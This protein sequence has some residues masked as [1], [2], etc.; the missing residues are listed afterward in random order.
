[1]N[2]SNKP[3]VRLIWEM[4]NLSVN[5]LIDKVSKHTDLKYFLTV[6]GILFLLRWLLVLWIGAHVMYLVYRIFNMVI[7]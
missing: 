5:E 6:A 2:Q 3:K 7:G 1:M 4:R